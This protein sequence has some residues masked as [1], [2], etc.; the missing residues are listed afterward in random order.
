[1]KVIHWRDKLAEAVKHVEQ[2]RASEA[3]VDRV[4][5]VQRI[6]VETITLEQAEEIIGHVVWTRTHCDDC[7]SCESIV[8]QV[9]DEPDYDSATAC[10]CLGCAEEAARMLRQAVERKTV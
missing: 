4:Q 7:G 9:G 2:Q 1:M 5:A 8:V 6:G 10:L 3:A